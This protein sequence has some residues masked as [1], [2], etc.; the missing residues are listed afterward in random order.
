MMKIEAFDMD[1]FRNMEE[2]GFFLEV[3]GQMRTSGC[4]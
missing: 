2:F 4:R 3:N 1:R